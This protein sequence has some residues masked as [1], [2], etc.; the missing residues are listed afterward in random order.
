MITARELKDFLEN[1]PG[2]WLNY[3]IVVNLGMNVRRDLI[4]TTLEKNPTTYTDDKIIIF[5]KGKYWEGNE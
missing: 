2:E 3:Q 1:V 4:L 5:D